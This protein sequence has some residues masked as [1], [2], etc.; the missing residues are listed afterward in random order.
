MTRWPAEWEK[1]MRRLLGAEYPAF[2]AQM[3]RPPVR[4]VRVNP[5]RCDA[6]RFAAL[7][8]ENLPG[9]TLRPV[10]FAP[11]GFAAEGMLSGRHPWHHAGVFYLQEP[12]A[13]AAVTAAGIAPGMRVLDLC[14][15]PGGKSTQAAGAL[16]GRGFLLSNEVMPGRTAALLSNLERLGVRNAAVTCERPDRLCAALEGGFDVVLVDAPCSGEGLFRREPAAAREWGPGLPEACARRQ[17][18]ILQSARRAVR[19][20]GVLVYSTCTFAPEENEGVVDAFLQENPDFYIEE[21]PAAF[22]RPAM[23]EWAGAA[24]GVA[25]ARRILPQDGGEGHFV[26]RLRRAG[27]DPCR[28]KPAPVPPPA[29]EAFEA[30]C[31][32]VFPAGVAGIPCRVGDE[33][34]LLP[35]SPLP[36]MRGMRLLRAGVPA[37]TLRRTGR[38][39]ERFEPA[40]GLFMAAG[41]SAPAVVC[42]LPAGSGELAAWLH[43]EEIPAPAGVPAGF[44]AVWA[45]GFPVGFGKISGGRIKNHYPKGLRNFGP[46]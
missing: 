3:G 14:A 2:A 13:M 4:G 44:A 16:M 12:S 40:H 43:G 24:P 5:L 11:E 35:E 34:F 23:P 38:G 8:E 36:D 20:G 9:V 46:G 10:P 7:A 22:G 26:A 45:G 17:T 25:R 28:V 15:A 32:E 19:P 31:R 1:R 6:R 18:L 42:D 33:V 39:A 27:D 30:F 41:G 37:G 21:I 29:G